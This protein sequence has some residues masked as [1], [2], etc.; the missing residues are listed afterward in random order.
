[1][2]QL[3]R[4][5]LGKANSRSNQTFTQTQYNDSAACT[6]LCDTTCIVTCPA[7]TP[8]MAGKHIQERVYTGRGC[9]HQI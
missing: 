4:S 6:P 5:D 1:M 3:I 8:R 2:A 9:Q 7:V